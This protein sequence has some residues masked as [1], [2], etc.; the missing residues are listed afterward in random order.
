MGRMR[1]ATHPTFDHRE[2]VR[3]RDCDAMGQANNA[4]YA[5]YPEEA[6]IG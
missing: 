5:T 2:H 4:V 3:F 1:S 6:P